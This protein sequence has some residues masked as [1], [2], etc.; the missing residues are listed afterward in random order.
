MFSRQD[1]S[2]TKSVLLSGISRGRIIRELCEEAVVIVCTGQGEVVIK[3]IGGD[4][5]GDFCEEY[6]CVRGWVLA[7]ELG[8]KWVIGFLGGERSLD[9]SNVEAAYDA[10]ADAFS[11]SSWLMLR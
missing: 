4:T 6:M 8:N 9:G 7:T 2:S 11:F 5:I 3:E 10:T 1:S